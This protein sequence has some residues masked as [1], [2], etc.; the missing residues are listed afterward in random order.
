MCSGP[1]SY[2]SSP[3]FNISI[4]L[5]SE[6]HRKKFIGCKSYK[7]SSFGFNSEQNIC[8]NT[9]ESNILIKELED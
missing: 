7:E 1:I 3:H 8:L 6:T 9:Y 2:H 5:N 4:S